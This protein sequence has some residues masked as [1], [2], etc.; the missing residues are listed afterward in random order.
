[1]ITK[2]ENCFTESIFD[3]YALLFSEEKDIL[4][5]LKIEHLHHYL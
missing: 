2:K 3:T 4:K 5:K 1:M